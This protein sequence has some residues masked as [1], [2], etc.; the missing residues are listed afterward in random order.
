MR[1]QDREK[2]EGKVC[3]YAMLA[4]GEAETLWLC[5]PVNRLHLGAD[6]SILQY[7]FSSLE[8]ES[9]GSD[10]GRWLGNYHEKE[11]VQS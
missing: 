9:S 2:N 8:I 5:N 11:A 6:N 3:S 10:S 4:V 7:V 1:V